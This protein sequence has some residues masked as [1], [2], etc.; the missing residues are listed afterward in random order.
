MKT[1]RKTLLFSAAFFCMN[2][3]AQVMPATSAGGQRAA[4]V[5]VVPFDPTT[6]QNTIY[7]LATTINTVNNTA[8]T[9]LNT[10][11]TAINGAALPWTG[12]FLGQ[13][14][15]VESLNGGVYASI[16]GDGRVVLS[17]AHPFNGQDLG[18]PQFN[19]GVTVTTPYAC[20]ASSGVFVGP[21]GMTVSSNRPTN[22]SLTRFDNPGN[23]SDCAGQGGQ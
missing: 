8:Y 13:Q 21:I 5:A 10:A 14:R 7:T 15:Y 23:P 20:G 11:T 19:S 6:L 2:L 22:W 9:A 17:G 4:S 16:L 1:H 12:Y 18:L 3:H